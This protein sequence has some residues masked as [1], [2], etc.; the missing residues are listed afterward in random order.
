MEMNSMWFQYSE[1]ND[2]PY[3]ISSSIQ[4]SFSVAFPNNIKIVDYNVTTLK[5]A[6]STIDYKSEE[7]KIDLLRYVQTLSEQGLH[8]ITVQINNTTE[9]FWY[10]RPGSASLQKYKIFISLKNESE[11]TKMRIKSE[12]KIP[13]GRLYY[14][15]GDYPFRFS[16]PNME[17]NIEYYYL[18]RK[19]EK[20]LRFCLETIDIPDPQL[21]HSRKECIDFGLGIEL[22]MS[23]L[24]EV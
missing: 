9:E 6:K 15:I 8:H 18:I 16:F 17:K 5:E 7:A 2:T 10:Y 22:M 13:S 11:T 24:E 20:Q 21:V 1:Q 4:D 14:M 23:K 12:I 19:T 3:L